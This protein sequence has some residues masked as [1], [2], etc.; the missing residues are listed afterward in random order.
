MANEWRRI[1]MKQIDGQRADILVALANVNRAANDKL[2][3]YEF[4]GQLIEREWQ[5]AKTRG[6]VS[7]AMIGLNEAVET[8]VAG[9]DVVYGDLETGA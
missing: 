1:A 8:F 4:M 5:N 7:D 2:P 3:L 9:N 6:L